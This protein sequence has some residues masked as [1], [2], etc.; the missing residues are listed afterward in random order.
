MAYLGEQQQDPL[1][2]CLYLCAGHHDFFASLLGVSVTSV[3]QQKL[4]CSCLVDF[5]S[6]HV[7]PERIDYILPLKLPDGQPGPVQL[8]DLLAA[9]RHDTPENLSS[10]P[11]CNA[12]ATFE[13]THQHAFSAVVL[14]GLTRAK[15]NNVAIDLP[16]DLALNSTPYRLRAVAC[17]RGTVDAGHYICFVLEQASRL[18]VRYND[19]ETPQRLSQPPSAM[20]THCAFAV[21]ERSLLHTGLALMAP[22]LP[23]PEALE[24]ADAAH[25]TTELA[26]HTDLAHAWKASSVLFVHLLYV[27][28]CSDN[29]VFVVIRACRG[30]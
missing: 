22:C 6:P 30:S 10:C 18:W 2:F 24:Q 26:E 4:P 5:G 17:H 14:L 8:T 20:S 29:H 3:V 11:I 15:G 1:E 27:T 13:A 28:V 21:Y 7:F 25:A 12:K 23:T 19:G 16:A 9:M